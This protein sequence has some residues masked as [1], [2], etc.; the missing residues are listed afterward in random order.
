MRGRNVS[1]GN[2][3]PKFQGN[4]NFQPSLAIF[5]VMDLKSASG[6]DPPAGASVSLSFPAWLVHL[7]L[8]TGDLC[9]AQQHSG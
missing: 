9:G 3:T 2:Q 5:S 8:C 4:V 7:I 6:I 1:H